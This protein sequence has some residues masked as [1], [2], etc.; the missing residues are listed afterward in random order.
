MGS[1]TMA[2]REDK[3]CLDCTTIRLIKHI[4][5]MPIDHQ[6]ILLKK[7]ESYDQLINESERRENPRELYSEEVRFHFAGQLIKGN[8]DNISSGGLSIKSDISPKIGE[9]IKLVFPLN[10]GEGKH[11]A[12]VV[13]VD[14]GGFSVRF[15]D[16]LDTSYFI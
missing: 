7:L 11:H 9:I 12:E 6:N 15:S 8:A 16:P 2:N 10:E 4:L 5:D 1:E 13:R 14:T 3:S